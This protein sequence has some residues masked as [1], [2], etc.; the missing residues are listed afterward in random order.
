VDEDVRA[1]GGG[2][3]EAVALL[4]V[5]PLHGTCLH[6]TSFRDRLSGVPAAQRLSIMPVMVLGGGA[7]AGPGFSVSRLATDRPPFGHALPGLQAVPAENAERPERF[8]AISP[9]F[10]PPGNLRPG[11]ALTLA[12]TRNQTS[13]E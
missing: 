3:D 11:R 10:P 12:N 8:P 7:L 1:A 2:L 4:G 5:E 6:V 9:V 13:M